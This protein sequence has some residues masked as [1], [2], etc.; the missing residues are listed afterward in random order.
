MDLPNF[1][2]DWPRLT[3][4]NTLLPSWSF[5]E[6]SKLG[7][8]PSSNPFDQHGQLI[9]ANHV[10]ARNL[11][12]PCPKSLRQALEKDSVDRDIWL[13]SYHEEKGSLVDNKTFVKLTLQQY[14][15]L[16]LKKGAPK[17]IPTMCV[18]TV[19]T[20]ENLAPDRAKSRIVVL[21]NLEDRYWAKCD[22]YAPVLQYSSLRLL[23]SMSVEKR[24]RLKQGD[25]KNA[26][27]QA[28]L[29]DDELTIVRP[30]LGDPDADLDEFWLL[31][32][33]LYG[34]ARAPRHWFEKM[35]NAMQAM[36]LKPSAHDPCLFVGVPSWPGDLASA[37]GTLASSPDDKP[38]HV[39]IYVDDFVYFSEDDAIE[40]RFEQ[41]LKSQF[42]IDFMGTV[43]WFLGTHFQ[44]SE[45]HDGH[46]SVLLSQK[47]FAQNLVERHRLN[48]I[49]YNPRVSPYRSGYPID[50]F[51]SA[52]VDE[53]DKHFVR[54]RHSYRSLVGGLN[55]LA[56]NTR[57]DLA[58]VV[59]FLA[60]Y[61]HCPSKQHVESALWVVRYL[62]STTSHGIAYHSASPS[63]SQA[64]VHYPFPH[65]A[66]AYHDAT[67]PPNDH[68]HLMT[69]YSD[70]NYGSQI[71][72]SI[73]DG[74]E[75]ELF[76]F[77]SMS[78]FLIMRCGGP[79]AWKAIRQE[80][81]SRSTCEAE[82]WA[83]DE[84]TKE[85][86]SLRH[87]CNDM[88]LPDASS[89]T[90]LFN[91]NRGTVDWAKGTST[92]GMRHLNQQSVCVGESIQDKE[93]ALHHINGL[94]NPSDIFTKEMRDTTHFC[95]LRDSFMMSEERFNTFVSANSV[96][97]DASWTD[98]IAL[99]H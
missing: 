63:S 11:K 39:G 89:P 55:W 78:G 87:R 47:A 77:C 48:N 54:R 22:R 40:S 97:L 45:H 88:N 28:T 18:L 84:A 98:G 43:N 66:D 52:E 32:R 17:A 92:K 27:V 14:K 62:R 64:Y 83:V 5:R 50:S 61:N 75:V 79:I 56:T 72:N 38:L 10:S 44:W 68:M 29:P 25:F 23:T 4:D 37:D 8:T 53:D 58:P 34:L 7:L 81:C 69:G 74:E 76:K 94:V 57:P 30:P 13:K 73:P 96:W 46:L 2:T 67:P 51:P 95:E 59:S 93:I 24:R 21:G 86:L 9:S 85:I 26:F 49:N 70:A 36:G 41:I 82:I 80:R 99:G 16:R 6:Y 1:E 71:G 15:D 3:C 65:D 42:N 31:K 91:D 19:K 20:D 60:S 33:S 35:S 90:L 12:K